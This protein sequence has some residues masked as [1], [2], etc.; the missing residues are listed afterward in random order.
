[1]KIFVL[2]PVVVAI[3]TCFNLG[4]T[5]WLNKG[6]CREISKTVYV[7]LRFIDVGMKD[8]IHESC[9]NKNKMKKKQV[10]IIVE[11]DFLKEIFLASPQH[12]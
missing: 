4:C 8:F 12:L 3:K 1:M 9:N 6:Q 2:K 10:L 11:N 7:Y 5:D